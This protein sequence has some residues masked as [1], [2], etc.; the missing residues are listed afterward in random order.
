[1]KHAETNQQVLNQGLD[2]LGSLRRWG[3]VRCQFDKC[4][5]EILTLL[6]ILLHFL[7]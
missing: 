7:S 4:G 5:Q 6:H 2:V 3:I 1:M